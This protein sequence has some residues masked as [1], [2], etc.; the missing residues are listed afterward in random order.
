MK[1]ERRDFAGAIESR[2]PGLVGRIEKLVAGSEKKFSGEDGGFLWEHSVLVASLAFRLA[3]PETV[4]PWIA[5]LAALLHDAGKFVG[6][7]YHADA[8]PE[9]EGSAETARRVLSAAGVKKRVADEIGR[10]L[11]ALYREGKRRNRLADVLHDADFLSKSGTLGVANFFVKSALRGRNLERMVMDSLSKEMTYAAALP[12]NMRTAEGR[13]LAAKKSRDALRFH[14]ARGKD[15]EMTAD[16]LLVAPRGCGVCGRTWEVGFR[17]EKGVK[18]ERL[19]ADLRC[20]SCGLA[21]TI[22]FCLPEITDSALA[23][24]THSN[25]Y[26]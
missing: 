6:G 8:R 24:A 9:E 2:H 12:R 11:V 13:R 16:F 26:R 4:E 23:V 15:G 7:R 21:H 3:G 10:G 18:C 14:R 20:P 25:K 22:S 5:A 1:I 17:T 19:E